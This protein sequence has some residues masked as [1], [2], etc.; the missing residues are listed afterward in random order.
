MSFE[1]MSHSSICR[2]RGY[3]V[4]A[5]VV[6]GLVV[7]GMVVRGMV[8]RDPVGVPLNLFERERIENVYL[9]LDSV[10]WCDV[11]NFSVKVAECL[12]LSNFI[13]Q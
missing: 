12:P 9:E 8:V 1:I 13:N 7:R 2:I 4:R 5:S 6:R 10:F 11:F 3:V